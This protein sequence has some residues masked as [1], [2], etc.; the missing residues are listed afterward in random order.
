MSDPIP[1][2]ISAA[3]REGWTSAMVGCPGCRLLRTRMF[4]Q[5]PQEMPLKLLVRRL[6]C[7]AP[8]CGQRADYF[9]LDRIDPSPSGYGQPVHVHL[10]VL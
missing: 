10:Q 4:D 5:F 1:E 9:S 6:R 7:R 2:T 3:I 8:G